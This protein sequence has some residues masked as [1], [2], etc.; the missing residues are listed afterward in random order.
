[1][2]TSL[3]FVIQVVIK[4]VKTFVRTNKTRFSLKRSLNVLFSLYAR[5]NVSL[6]CSFYDSFYCLSQHLQSSHTLLF[7]IVHLYSSVACRRQPHSFLP[8][9]RIQ[10]G[11]CSQASLHRAE[12]GVDDTSVHVPVRLS[13]SSRKLK[14]YGFA[15]YCFKFHKIT[16]VFYSTQLKSPS[17]HVIKS[18]LFCQI[19]TTHHKV[20]G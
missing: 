19:L 4:L 2:R 7:V 3:F 18:I 14:T 15:P 6:Y 1:M 10:R 8:S 11:T 17:K 16:Y 13:T 9:T 12:L 5:F 20:R